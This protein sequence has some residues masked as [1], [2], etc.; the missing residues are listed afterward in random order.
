MV[1]AVSKSLRIEIV[2]DVVCPW[3]Y[4]G[5]ANL[6]K[7]ISEL[8]LEYQN[9]EIHIEFKPFRLDPN[10]PS[11][12]LP[13]DEV[14]SKKFGSKERMLEIFENTIQAA[15]DSGIQMEFKT[16]IM[17]PNTLDSH[18]LIRLAKEFSLQESMAKSL[19]KAY[20]TDNLDLTEKNTLTQIAV[21]VGIP[22][23]RIELF[24]NENEF[25][26]ETLEE[27]THIRELGIS[28]VP[29]FILN[30]RYAFSGAQPVETML[31]ILKDIIENKS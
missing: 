21:Q 31:E 3:C 27:E 6:E 28:G 8:K 7:A 11:S 5:K 4:I 9:L 25:W 16:G 17:Q 19:F 18:R 23:N 10:L 14:L 20:F 15:S 26:K 1:N 13:R 24:W 2:S 12:G 30:H 29:F 22:E